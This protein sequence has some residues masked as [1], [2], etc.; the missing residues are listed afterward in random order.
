MATWLKKNLKLFCPN[1]IINLALQITLQ[2]MQ[3]QSGQRLAP[4][5]TLNNLNIFKLSSIIA[6]QVENF[7]VMNLA[8]RK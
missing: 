8:S 3:V 7:C 1:K 5:Q 2:L 6:K 4:S